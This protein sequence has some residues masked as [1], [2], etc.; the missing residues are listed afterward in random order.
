MLADL[1]FALHHHG[2]R[3]R[4]HA[5]HGGQ[6]KAAIAAVESRH[7]ARAVDA[8]Q[9]IGLATAA[10]GVGQALHLRVAAQ[11]VKTVADGLRR[12]ALQPQAL[13]GFG[14]VLAVKRVLRDQAKNQLALASRVAGV[15]E[16]AHVLAARLLHHRVQAR[17]GLVDG[18]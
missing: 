6:K 18:L 3:G 2:Q 11:V 12:H 7:G 9:P 8:H 10:G 4:L 17:L 16:R 14:R 1:F 5:A 15:D 13:H